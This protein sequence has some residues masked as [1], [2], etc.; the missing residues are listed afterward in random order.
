MDDLNEDSPTLKLT[1]EKQVCQWLTKTKA[2]Q[3][4]L[5]EALYSTE[6]Q[7][8]LDEYLDRDTIHVLVKVHG[9]GWVE[10]MSDDRRVRAEIID[11][12][13]TERGL[14]DLNDLANLIASVPGIACNY[15]PTNRKAAMMCRFM[16]V[17]NWCHSETQKDADLQFLEV[18][19]TLEE[20]YDR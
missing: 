7:R 10:V 15:W 14:H 11:L 4:A 13:S 9:D 19:K 16:S 20:K 6:G 2:G 3:K 12:P 1:T 17:F 18:L 5:F 8:L